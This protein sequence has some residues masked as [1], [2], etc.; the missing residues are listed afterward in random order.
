MGPPR[1]P[2]PRAAPARMRDGDRRPACRFRTG[3]SRRAAGA[4]GPSRRP[5][6][7]TGTDR[8]VRG[9]LLAVVREATGP[10][11]ATGLDQ[12]W[13]DAAQ[14]SRALASL[15]EDGL[16]VALTEHRYALPDGRRNAGAEIAG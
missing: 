10:V 5:Q 12:V 14:R 6:S 15:V 9:L 11:A 8:Q 4:A 3:R 2:A 13:P 7:Y 1:V 16:V